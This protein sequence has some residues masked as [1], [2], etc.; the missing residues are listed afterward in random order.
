MIT[1][2]DAE[3]HKVD[4]KAFSWVETNAFTISIPEHAIS[5]YTYVLARRNAGVCH[6]MVVMHKGYADHPTDVI[7]EDAR[8]HVPEPKSLLDFD[9]ESG[10]GTTVTRAPN[11][12]HLRYNSNDGACKF[13]INFK[14]L[15]GPYNPHDA[16]QNV[17][18]KQHA[19]STSAGG[20]GQ[21]WSTGHFDMLGHMTGAL[22]LDG[23]TYKVD[24]VDGMDHSWGP[25]PEWEMG[26]IAWVNISLGPE[27]AFHILC[28]SEFV[29]GETVHGPLTFGH[30]CENGKMIALTAVKVKGKNRNFLGA[31]REFTITDALG[32]TWEVAG[33]GI[34]GYAL[35][36]A[37]PSFVVYSTLY[38]WTMG[39]RVGHAHIQEVYGR[40]TLGRMGRKARL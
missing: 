15:V 25:R 28:P 27:L 26:S 20:W 17:L 18:R 1:A 19:D 24:C 31:R 3:Y 14:A 23:K 36:T 29:D 11:D 13:D 8:M 35:S 30:M 9:L 5:C 34:G 40:G 4:P 38:R 32:R 16:E 12:Y 21:A 2:A 37:Y 22:T 33:E 10:F 7:W 6:T 39:G